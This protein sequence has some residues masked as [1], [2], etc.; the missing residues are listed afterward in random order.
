MPN[1]AVVW[2]HSI[3]KNNYNCTKCSEKLLNTDTNSFT[4]NV[5]FDPDDV[6]VVHCMNCGIVIGLARERPKGDV[7]LGEIQ[8]FKGAG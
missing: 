2:K 1:L 7:K 6:E 4:S 5:G 3:T 8:Q